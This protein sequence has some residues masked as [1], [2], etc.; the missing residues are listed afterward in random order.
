MRPR[1]P[2]SD[3]QQ[4]RLSNKAAFLKNAHPSRTQRQPTTRAH[5]QRSYFEKRAPI[6]NT[7]TANNTC[8]QPGGYFGKCAPID[9]ATT[10]NITCFQPGGLFKKMRARREHSDSRQHMLSTRWGF[11]EAPPSISQR[12]P[13]THAFKQGGYF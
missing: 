1:R 9:P 10:A 6:E 12:Q 8:F 5:N 3:S 4:R 13:T 7:A 2:H 11:E